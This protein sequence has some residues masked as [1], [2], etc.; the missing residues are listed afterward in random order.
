M[1]FRPSDVST[2]GR[3]GRPVAGAW[4]LILLFASTAPSQPLPEDTTVLLRG[5]VTVAGTGEAVPSARVD[6]DPSGAVTRTDSS[7]RFRVVLDRTGWITITVRHPAAGRRDTVVRVAAGDTTQLDWELAVPAY[8]MPDVGVEVRDP[9]LAGTGF[10]RRRG[11]GR[12]GFF[13]SPDSLAI[14]RYRNLSVYQILR[15]TPEALFRDVFRGCTVLYVDGD[16]VRM[17]GR[18][19]W[20]LR[21]LRQ[22]DLAGIEVL[23]PGEAPLEWQR[24]DPTK[25]DVVLVW[26]NARSGG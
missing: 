18:K 3:L 12:G 25:C 13:M 20:A 5:R 21:E 23:G 1:L 17:P 9:G 19:R 22:D 26:T 8:R 2:V 7:G 16:H 11:D 15:A 6:L 4:A 14:P 10:Y 24:G